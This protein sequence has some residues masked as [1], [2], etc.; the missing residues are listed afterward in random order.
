MI[1]EKKILTEPEAWRLIAQE[2]ERRGLLGCGLCREVSALY[3][4]PNVSVS[5]ATFIKMRQ[6]IYDGLNLR[7]Q[8]KEGSDITIATCDES[9]PR[10][11]A[12]YLLSYL[13]EE[14]EEHADAKE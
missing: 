10:I 11:L 12:A 2:V 5:A 6:R 9:G 14:E 8:M 13:A 3:Y 4:H 7:A 1:I